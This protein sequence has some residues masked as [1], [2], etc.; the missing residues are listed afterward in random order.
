[1]DIL[2]S[3]PPALAQELWNLILSYLYGFTDDLRACTLVSRSLCA[4]AQVQLFHDIILRPP[5]PTRIVGSKFAFPAD[6]TASCQR[7]RAVLTRKPHLIP[8]V[9]RVEIYFQPEIITHILEVGFFRLE[10]IQIGS[11]RF[12]FRPDDRLMELAQSLLGLPSLRRIELLRINQTRGFMP[13]LFHNSNP[14][15]QALDISMSELSPDITL[16]PDST[17]IPAVSPT[18]RCWITELRL[19]HSPTMACWMF[20]PMCPFNFTRLKIADV[21]SSMCSDVWRILTSAKRTLTHLTLSPGDLKS[22]PDLDLNQLPSLTYLHMDAPNERDISEILPL[23]QDIDP[24][25]RFEEIIITLAA[26]GG[27]PKTAEVRQILQI[28]DH[29]FDSI[30]LPWLRRVEI[31]LFNDQQDQCYAENDEQDTKLDVV[32]KERFYIESLLMLNARGVLMV[33]SFH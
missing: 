7:L 27:Q 14:Q 12:A 30:P 3:R 6:E 26:Y 1:M 15:L 11:M 9:R 33:K 22:H 25:N 19:V 13:Y 16:F 2:E 18:G 4:A 23:L 32:S 10:E 17:S 29:I 28:F 24:E 20:D 21:S 31:C 8:H 5:R